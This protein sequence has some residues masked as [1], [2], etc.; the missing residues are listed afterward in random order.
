MSSPLN[1]QA[2]TR[3][4]TCSSANFNWTGGKGP[5]A[6]TFEPFRTTQ[7]RLDL[8]NISSQDVTVNLNYP[9]GTSIGWALIGADNATTS[10]TGNIDFD[11]SGNNACLF[12]STSSNKTGLGSPS[13][14]SWGV[15]SKGQPESTP[16]SSFGTSA[17]SPLT[18]SWAGG[19]G[20]YDVFLQSQGAGIET[21]WTFGVGSNNSLTTTLPF[22]S[23]S[24]YIAVIAD[25]G[26]DATISSGTQTVGKGGNSNCLLVGASSSSNSSSG[27]NHGALIGGVV[28]G[29]L[30][31]CLIAAIVLFLRRRNQ[32]MRKAKRSNL[33][34]AINEGQ[35]QFQHSRASER[36][37]IPLGRI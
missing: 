7:P 34:S 11:D 10:A 14:L 22:A 17:C 33:T 4:L 5:Y 12:Q 24:Q 29:I 18:L 23:G 35:Y 32:L 1:V 28:G 37:A 8:S 31:L 16:P 25:N 15:D 2:P 26:Q 9:G 13:V 27:T 30:G 36:D 6:L 3:I 20:S 19:S 21:T